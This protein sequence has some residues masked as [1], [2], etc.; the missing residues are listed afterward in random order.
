MAKL[1]KAKANFVVDAGIM[2]SFLGLAVSGFVLW[3]ILPSGG[4][5]GG[6]GLAEASRVFILGR[7]TWKLLHD[8]LAVGVVAGVALHLVLHWNWIV[9]MV[10]NMW[11]EAFAS[12]PLA[13]QLEECEL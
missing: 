13:A 12:R 8:W 3:L 7:E 10:R 4:Y 6:R 2:A 1:S 5:Q 11:R 9:C